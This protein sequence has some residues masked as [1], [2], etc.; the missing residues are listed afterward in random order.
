ML[1]KSFSE[2]DVSEF[3]Y[4]ESDGDF[5]GASGLKVCFRGH[6]EAAQELQF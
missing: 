3:L 2:E 4:F 6:Q 5:V 1:Q